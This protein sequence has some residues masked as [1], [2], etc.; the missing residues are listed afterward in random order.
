MAKKLW[1]CIVIK[2][3]M[4]TLHDDI[5]A[6]LSNHGGRAATIFPGDWG[7]AG[8]QLTLSRCKKIDQVVLNV[9]HIRYRS[10]VFS[11]LQYYEQTR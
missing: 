6:P 4:P 7:A 3:K 1:Y 10:P 5:S 2:Y 11:F 9:L 8:R